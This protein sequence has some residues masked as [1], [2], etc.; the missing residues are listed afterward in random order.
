LPEPFDGLP[1]TAEAAGASFETHC[2]VDSE[3]IRSHDSCIA[4]ILPDSHWS[5]VTCGLSDRPYTAP[6]APFASFQHLSSWEGH[7]SLK[8]SLLLPRR[9]RTC[10][11]VSARRVG[12][13]DEDA[14][15]FVRRHETTNACLPRLAL[16]RMIIGRVSI[17]AKGRSQ[18]ARPLPIAD[19]HAS[20]ACHSA[21]AHICA[22]TGAHLHQD[23]P[24]SSPRPALLSSRDGSRPCTS[25]AN[26]SA[27]PAAAATVAAHSRSRTAPSA[28]PV[29]T[30][31]EQL[32]SV[33]TSR[34]RLGLRNPRAASHNNAERPS[35]THSRSAHALGAAKRELRQ[36]MASR[37]AFNPKLWSGAAHATSSTAGASQS[38]W[39]LPCKD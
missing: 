24:T 4:T 8:D 16:E 22:R 27:R 5:S 12:L 23:W 37:P 28:G 29:P 13:Q 3:E 21:R 38:L 6:T 19:P 20:I 17:E 11:E 39:L 2:L 30:S 26:W 34:E 9:R 7:N 15:A 14:T 35:L 31:R 18:T 25:G 1:C 32:G 33:P 10:F 36:K